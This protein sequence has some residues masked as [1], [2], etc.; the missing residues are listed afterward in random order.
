MNY[1]LIMLGTMKIF[2]TISFNFQ[3]KKAFFTNYSHFSDEN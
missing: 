2:D 1:V 3:N